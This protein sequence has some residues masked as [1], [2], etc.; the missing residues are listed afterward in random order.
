[1]AKLGERV[2]AGTAAIV[3]DR[4]RNFR[5]A[6]KGLWARGKFYLLMCTTFAGGKPLKYVLEAIE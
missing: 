3:G 5:D 1:M 4:T 2:V 6:S